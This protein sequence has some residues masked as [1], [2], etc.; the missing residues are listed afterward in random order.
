MVTAVRIAG[1]IVLTVAVAAFLAASLV[2][3]APGAGTGEEQLDVR[4][5]A[6]SRARIEEQRRMDLELAGYYRRRMAGWLRGDFGESQSLRRPVGELLRERIGPTTKNISI[7]LATA[8]AAGLAGALCLATRTI[9]AAGA[10]ASLAGLL[11][12]C[13]PA[14]AL[15]LF[16]AASGRRGPA[17]CGLALGLVLY[18]RVLQYGRNLLGRAYG[19]AHVTVARARGI[20]RTRILCWHVLPVA[21]P[22]LVSFAAVSV[23]LAVSAAIPLEVIL[24]V[25]GIGQLAWQAAL[26]RDLNLLVNVTVL[27][28]L[29]VVIA[30]T[31]A[32]A[33]VERTGA[34]LSGVKE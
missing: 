32:D 16:A 11:L 2:R 12:Q 30:S 5:S 34:G 15:A 33:L 17:L 24:D 27:V 23:S 19:H 22:Q 20:G 18:P 3:F 29:L 4:W 9:P 14:G 10:F 1:R 13:V 7:G 31:L 26:A 8:W 28:C 25:P 6:S 21:A